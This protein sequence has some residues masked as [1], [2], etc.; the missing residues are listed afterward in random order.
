MLIEARPFD[1]DLGNFDDQL[2]PLLKRIY[3]AR[4]ITDSAALERKLGCLP[5]P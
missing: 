2:D 3:L 5:A 4:G 1:A